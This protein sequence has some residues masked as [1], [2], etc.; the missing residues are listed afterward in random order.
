MQT[1]K[2]IQRGLKLAEVLKKK[3]KPQS[4][5]IVSELTDQVYIASE[6][7]LYWI[8]CTLRSLAEAERVMDQLGISKEGLVEYGEIIIRAQGDIKRIIK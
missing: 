2:L 1:L 7:A 8:T 3:E 4:S 6:V 5:Q